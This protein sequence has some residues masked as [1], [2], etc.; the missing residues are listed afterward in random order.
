[1]SEIIAFA[2]LL[3]GVLL[4]AAYIYERERVADCHTDLSQLLHDGRIDKSDLRR[5]GDHSE[6]QRWFD[7]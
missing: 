5:S 1:M 3:F 4:G 6:L 7:E 2:S